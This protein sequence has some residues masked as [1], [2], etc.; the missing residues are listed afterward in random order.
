MP[1]V[2]DHYIGAEILLSRWDDM[3]RGHVVAWSHDDSG[4][5][6]KRA[7]TNPK[8]NFRMYQFEFAWGN[9]QNQPPMSLL[10][11]STPNAMQM[12]ININT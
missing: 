4:N 8:L 2:G 10:S 11:Q 1:E 7:H 9:L 6:I 5:T 3:A 12:E